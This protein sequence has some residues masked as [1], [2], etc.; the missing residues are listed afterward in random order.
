[1]ADHF[2]S[3]QRFFGA[4]LAAVVAG[5]VIFVILP[6]KESTGPEHNPPPSTDP[7]PKRRPD[8]AAKELVSVVFRPR[9]FTKGLRRLN[10]NVNNGEV[11]G[12]IVFA[13]YRQELTVTAPVGRWR[14]EYKIIGVDAEIT[15]SYAAQYGE[16][17]LVEGPGAFF[18]DAFNDGRG[19]Y[20]I[21]I[22]PDPFR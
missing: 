7:K 21:T 17:F 18:V 1:M 8:S 22:K 16:D 20:G 13:P 2:L 10:F 14:I 12:D 11:V 9:E 15:H 3:P 5:V 6:N 19:M 4:V